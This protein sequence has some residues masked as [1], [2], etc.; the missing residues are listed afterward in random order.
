MPIQPALQDDQSQNAWL[1]QA[2][3]EINELLD[4]RATTGTQ[5]PRGASLG[6]EHFLTQNES[7]SNV[8]G[9]YK[10]VDF[11]LGWILLS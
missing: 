2:T 6:S 9:W 4:L 5:F 7:A 1:D 8:V 10:F 11:N 3:A